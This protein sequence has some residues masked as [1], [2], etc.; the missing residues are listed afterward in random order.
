[1]GNPV[2]RNNCIN[3]IRIIAAFQVMFG[4]LIEH[5]ELPGNESILHATYFFRGVPIFFV[6]SGFLMWFSI[7][8][9]RTYGQYLK[10]RF[11]RIYPELWIAVLVEIC[12]LVLLYRGWN[13]KELFLFAFAQGTIF[14][15]WTPDSLRGYG[16]GTPNG[17]LWTIGVM[18]QFYIVAWLFYNLMKNRKLF[19]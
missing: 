14:Q 19:T 4:H 2:N 8:R 5:L 6:I 12:V 16:V 17:A 7:A 9:S 18:I 15:F 1:M 3:L 10:K 13:I 11:W